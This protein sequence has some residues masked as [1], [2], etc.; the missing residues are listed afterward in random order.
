MSLVDKFKDWFLVDKNN[1]DTLEDEEE[2]FEDT[3]STSSKSTSKATT[4]STTND[5]S[6]ANT[7]TT[8]HSNDTYT[9]PSPSSSASSNT[10]YRRDYD[11][12]SVS[13]SSPN[14]TNATVTVSAKLEVVLVRPEVF[15]DAKQIA[16]H[17]IKKKTVVLNLENAK[18]E[19][20]RRIIDFL[21][22][23]AYANG[24]SIKAVANRTYIITPSGV[25]FVGDELV[26]EL[27]S[28]GVLM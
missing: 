18:P 5:T 28:S 19:N 4:N 9:S 3:E 17:L 6:S 11:R 13:N 1:Q 24:G 7:S 15:T 21:A 16:D 14:S 26:G 20:K 12:P 8:N 25:G 27:E 23:V 10:S 22:G 2:D